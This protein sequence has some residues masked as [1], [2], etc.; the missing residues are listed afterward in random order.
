MP[1]S[2][3]RP[4]SCWRLAIPFALLTHL[5]S[6]VAAA[7]EPLSPEQALAAFQLHPDCRIELVAAEPDVIDPVHI[8]FDTAGR[9]W[10]VEYS[11]Y[12]HGPTEGQPGASRIRVLT[13]ADGDGRYGDPVTFAERLLFATGLLPWRDG[14]IV[15]TAGSVLFL[16][17]VDGDG[18]ADET[19]EWFRGFKEEN[20]QLRANHP[21]F[22][23][24]NQ[25]YIASGIRGGEVGPGRD[26][27][28]AFQQP[29]GAALPEPVSL[30]GRD[31]RF[32]P[33]TGRYEAV[34]GPG[35]FGLTFDDWGRRFL[36]DNRHP[37]KQIVL[38][39]WHLR[40]NPQVSIP[41]T[42]HDALPQGEQSRLYPIS[43]T[44]TTSNLHTNQFTAAC[45]LSIYRGTAL[46]P[47]M[48][49][50]VFVCDPTA[51]LVHRATLIPDGSVFSSQVENPGTEF[52][53][54]QD[55]WF[56]AVNTTTGPDGALYVVDMY[57]AVIEHP[58]FMPDELKTRPDLLLGTDRG[59]I[60]RVVARTAA[61]GAAA[62]GA[63]ATAGSTTG[64]TSPPQPSSAPGTLPSPTGS[65]ADLARFLAHPG[66]WQRE[67]AHRLLL[68]RLRDR[69]VDAAPL[70]ALLAGRSPQ[71]RAHAL[72][73]LQA[74]GRLTDEQL[75]AALAD[76]SPRVREV[77][78]R[79]AAG[80]TPRSAALEPALIQTL[81]GA[82]DGQLQ[83][84]ALLSLAA[85]DTMRDLAPMLT[86]LA[87]GSEGDPWRLR[88]IQL[89]T[90][91]P[92]A[93]TAGLL[94]SLAPPSAAL[95]ANARLQE[96]A[97]HGLAL[98]GTF[99]EQTARQ[100]TPADVAR[101]LASCKIALPEQSPYSAAIVL[102]LARGLRSARQP[103]MPTLAATGPGGQEY[104]ADLFA[105]ARSAATGESQVERSAAI[106]L[107]EFAP[108]DAASTLLEIARSHPQIIRRRQALEILARRSEP[109]IGPALAGNLAALSPE[110]RAATLGVLFSTPVRLALLL[111]EIEA[112]RCSPRLIDATRVKQLTTHRDAALRERA[113]KLFADSTPEAR[114]QAL[115][116]YQA[117]LTLDAD[118]LRGREVFRATC[119]VCHRV[120]GLGVDVAPDISD[121][122]VR[123]REYLLTAILDPNQA[124]DNNYFAYTLLDRDG[125]VH[126]GVLASETA[127]AV[128]LKQPEGKTVTIPREAIEELKSSGVSLMP[129]GLERNIN[130]Q[131]MADLLS[132]LKNW[133]YLDGVVPAEVIR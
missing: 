106:D 104:L 54:T 22:A 107:L 31:F 110:L 44:F 37:C 35:Q 66:G 40:S 95:T 64:A 52:L 41:Q 86:A 120:G 129:E 9:M 15:T 61:T 98:L 14:V 47:A 2:P 68:E 75:V 122:R 100:Q 121:S 33:L 76:E 93:V 1:L 81:A 112:E 117:C 69:E 28:T 50:D 79:I 21:T 131:Q 18:R 77:A 108:W 10:V 92:A 80:R 65:L 125:V 3:V 111:D 29:A 109:E 62:T 16:R 84:A 34:S 85:A 102:G 133:R 38:E 58:Q 4:A 127:T 60:Y 8:A 114:R 59:R 20:P 5:L 126:S 105:W 23:I 19:Q 43:R 82:E 128:T 73:L 72:W 49:G 97:L 30:S 63:A 48:A 90:R 88:A 51:N 83:L 27:A 17:D 67:T 53:A 45:G 13:D 130:H 101:V 87:A 119:S 89:A 124:I 71:A 132:Y 56:R 74:C 7:A 11:D 116:D 42:F 99:A 12:P 39:E 46:P 94:T 115:A 32:D 118:P 55:E 70:E 6:A 103:V 36:C 96:A 25:I 57:R 123:T 91:D 78:C 24:D 26:W 113:L